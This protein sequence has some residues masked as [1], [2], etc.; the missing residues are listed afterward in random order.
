MKSF[1]RFVKSDYPRLAVLDCSSQQNKLLRSHAF[2]DSLFS[3][4][5]PPTTEQSSQEAYQSDQFSLFPPEELKK[6]HE[7]HSYDWDNDAEFQKG[8]KAIY[9]TVPTDEKE[10]LKARQFYFSR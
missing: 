9:S 8:L 6:F 5:T 1:E 4:M 3:A 2:R 7:F 10:L